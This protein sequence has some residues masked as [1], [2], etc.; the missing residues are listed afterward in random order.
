MVYKM[1]GVFKGLK[2]ISQ[3]FDEWHEG[4]TGLLIAE[5]FRTIK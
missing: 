4:V 3:I 1:K 2:V 5:Q